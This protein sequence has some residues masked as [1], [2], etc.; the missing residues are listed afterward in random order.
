TNDAR[1]ILNKLFPGAAGTAPATGQT[2][3][4]SAPG[5]AGGRTLPNAAQALLQQQQLQQQPLQ[6]QQ[7]VL[8]GASANSRNAASQLH[9]ASLNN[10]QSAAR[11][12]QSRAFL[13][14]PGPAGSTEQTRNGNIVRTTAEGAVIDVHSPRNGMYIHHGLD[15][16]KHIL[17]NRPDHSR[18]Y[19]SSRGVQYVQ[20]PYMFRGRVF[21]HRTYYVQGQLFHQL[22]RPY[23]YGSTTL[24]VYATS[25]Y[26]EPGVY[27]WATSR[28]NAPQ[29]YNWEYLA[30][31]PPWYGYYKGYFTPE[32]TY[33][34]PTNWLADFVLAT[35]LAASYKVE[36]PTGP[37]PAGA[38]AAAVT[39]EVKQMIADEVGRQV[40]QESVEAQSAGQNREPPPGSIVQ[41]LA[42]GQSHVLVAASDLDLVD[43]EGRRCMISE[44]DVVQVVS[45][46]KPASGTA[47]AV[48]LASKGG[49]ECQR[50][51]QVE[52]ALNDLQEMQNHMREAID[53]GMATTNTAKKAASVTPAF[54]SA[55]PPPD[56]NAAHELDQEQQIAAQVEG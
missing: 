37:A 51:A 13:G 49:T 52:I 14:H 2:G 7:A 16:S 19:V 34:S 28:F 27:Q 3:T 8:K 20:H 6:Q 4:G 46:A 11:A 38:G 31:A 1:S 54:V 40:R 45:P 39:P 18:V 33:T 17:V 53:Q 5:N 36:P 15:G 55:A 9:M 24:D 26:Y 35:S 43:G 41:E 12:V 32:H 22:Y 30:N 47:D 48:V 29:P 50:S 25:R 21:D 10:G 42:D 23:P 44:G 56:A